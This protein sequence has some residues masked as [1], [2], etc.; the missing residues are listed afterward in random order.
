MLS[1]LI[2]DDWLNEERFRSGSI[3]FVPDKEGE[4]RNERNDNGDG[5]GSGGEDD[6]SRFRSFF[7]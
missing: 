6:E 2:V 3:P 5:G 4:E 7:D 1:S